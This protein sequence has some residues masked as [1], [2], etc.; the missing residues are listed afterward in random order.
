MLE[1]YYTV[2][3]MFNDVPVNELLKRCFAYNFFGTPKRKKEGIKSY[4]L[5]WHDFWHFVKFYYRKKWFDILIE[6]FLKE[7]LQKNA[8]RFAVLFLFI[9]IFF[10]SKFDS[11]CDFWKTIIL[12]LI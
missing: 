10:S 12:N 6:M 4:C 9:Y 3:K 2:E 1:N 7:E 5:T 11:D 8:W